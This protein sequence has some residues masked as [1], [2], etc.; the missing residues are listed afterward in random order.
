MC[1]LVFIALWKGSEVLWLVIHA[2]FVIVINEIEAIGDHSFEEITWPLTYNKILSISE[3]INIFKRRFSC[4]CQKVFKTLMN[5]LYVLGPMI[6]DAGKFIVN[7]T[8]SIRDDC[9]KLSL[10]LLSKYFFRVPLNGS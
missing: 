1:K 5:G 7:Q 8:R 3:N 9:L 6:H 10:N 4:I 2:S